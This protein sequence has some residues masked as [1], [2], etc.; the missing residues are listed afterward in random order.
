MKP[1]DV[2]RRG[3]AVCEGYAGLYKELADQLGLQCKKIS[4]HSKGYSWTGKVPTSSNHAWNAVKVGD[5]WYFIDS[6]WGA[7][8]LEGKK[9]VQKFSNFY[10][11]KSLINLE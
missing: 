10:W 2:L 9:Y 8:H 5:F 11:S 7:G 6:T 4:G 1:D 3:T